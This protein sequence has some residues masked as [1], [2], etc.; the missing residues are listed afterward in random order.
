MLDPLRFLRRRDRF[1]Q[2][3]AEETALLVRRYGDDAYWHAMTKLKRGDLTTRY[4]KLL[5]AAAKRLHKDG[6]R[7]AEERA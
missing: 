6:Y 3:V 1:Q 4:R 7:S 5:D 2:N